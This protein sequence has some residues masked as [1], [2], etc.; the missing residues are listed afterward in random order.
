M[1]HAC[2]A[3]DTQTP[4]VRPSNPYK[5]CAEGQSFEDIGSS[6]NSGVECDDEAIGY[7]FFEA[8]DDLLE[9]IEACDCAVDLSPGMIAYDYAIAADLDGFAGVLDALNAWTQSARLLNCTR[10]H[11]G[12]FQQEGSTA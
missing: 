3:S 11:G 12:T 4:N 1:S 6:T 10:Q 7:G 2:F 5:L 8:V 9:C